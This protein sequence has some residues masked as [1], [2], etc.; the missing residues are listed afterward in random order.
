M[1]ENTEHFC[2]I[3]VPTVVEHLFYTVRHLRKTLEKYSSITVF[4]HMINEKNLGWLGFI[5]DYTT[6]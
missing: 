3:K 4:G 2:W 5:G 1:F 6:Q